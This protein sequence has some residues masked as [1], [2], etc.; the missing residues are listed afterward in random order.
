MSLWTPDGERPIRRTDD[1]T[2]DLRDPYGYGELSD[3]EH[4]QA[5]EIAR[6]MAAIRDR[7]ADTP[8]AVVVAN[9]AMGLYELAAIHLGQQHPA[10]AEASVAIDAMSGMVEALPGRLGESEA[11]LRDAL[12][13]LRLA[14]VNLRDQ[15]P[16]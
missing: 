16:S 13:Q 7:L 8:A 4:A 9:H 3:D 2:P 1:D 5:E 12:A 6:E 14:F 10:F 15:H 11:V